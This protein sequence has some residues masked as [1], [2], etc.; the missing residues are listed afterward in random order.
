MNT[1]FIK[2]K[3]FILL[4]L[5]LALSFNE[6]NGQTPGLIY[7][8]A[9]GGGTSVLDPNGDGYI[10]KFTSGF[11]TD[12]QLESEIPF[13]SLVFPM[14]EPNS[15]L[16]SG[17]SCSFTDFVDQG[18]EDPAQ[19]YLDANGNWL[20]RLRMGSSSPNSK[21]YSILI[22]TDGKFGGSGPNADPQY[23]SS[24]P[25]FEIEIVLA[26]NF[27]VFVY[28]V[29]NNNCTP[30]P[31]LSYPGTTNYQKSVAL[32][33]SCG[34]PD[35]FYDLFVK[36]S[37]LT[38]AFASVSPSPVTINASTAVRMA[39]VDNMGAK[40]STV[41]SPASASDIAG[42][43]TSCGSLE[44]C[45]GVI[46][47]NY[48]PC[49]PGQVC[50]DR[51]KCPVIT[52]SYT[53]SSTVIS[54]TSTEANGTIVQVY[55]NGVATGTTTTVS[56]GAW[57]KSGFVL[58]VNDVIT[59]TA[60]ASGKTI[61]IGN[62]SSKIVASC[63]TLTPPITS[64]SHCGKSI[65]GIATAGALVRVYQGTNTPADIPGGGTIWT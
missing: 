7:S 65:Q 25:G 49:A 39:V 38:T 54:G 40:K 26:T 14:V 28:D 24:N 5:F 34:N 41:C 18:D 13:S 22:D 48:T 52:G 2:I 62:C 51:T 56:A 10:S 61:S 35:Y 47:D 43:D 29:N 3:N 6:V 53:T 60:I 17:P 63:S 1:K 11:V 23:S 30:L 20:F 55:I 9:T 37:D 64:A 15:D 31:S 32:T 36:M 50:A 12:D 44:N 21:S 57:T 46:I 19:S 8:P 33:T 27:G 59:A 45:F 58:A 42:I 4:T 16:S